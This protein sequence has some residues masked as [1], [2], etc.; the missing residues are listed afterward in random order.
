MMQPPETSSDISDFT[1]KPATYPPSLTN[2]NMDNSVDEK[3][4]IDI[5]PF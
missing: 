1:P 5:L 2:S 3:Y 4:D